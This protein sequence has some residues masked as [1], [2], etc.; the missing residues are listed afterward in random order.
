MGM[1]MR[2]RADT[3]GWGLLQPRARSMRRSPTLAENK[4]WQRLRRDQLGVWFRSQVVVGRFIAD[5]YCPA[6]GLI[7]EVDGGVHDTRGEADC[8]RDRMLGAL[9]LRV[10]RVRNEDILEDLDAVVRVIA[11]ALRL[12]PHAPPALP[13]EAGGRGGGVIG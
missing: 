5:F 7:V 1:T 8:E 12:S 11:A 9:N 2:W 4:L 10:L 13:G 3:E 6:R